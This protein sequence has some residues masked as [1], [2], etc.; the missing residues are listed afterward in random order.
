MA[1]LG[2]ILLPFHIGKESTP[3]EMLAVGDAA[4]RVAALRS[5][6]VVLALSLGL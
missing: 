3:R 4:D 1:E 5:R 2:A 6:D